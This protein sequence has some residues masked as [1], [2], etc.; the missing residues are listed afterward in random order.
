MVNERRRAYILGED[1]G[2]ICFMF[3]GVLSLMGRIGLMLFCRK[4]KS[5][6]RLQI[7]LFR[8]SS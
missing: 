2:F 8:G 7:L 1:I 3:S 6:I 5:L 4:E